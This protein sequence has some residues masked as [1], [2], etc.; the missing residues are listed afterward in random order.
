MS[1]SVIG[2]SFTVN[3]V[4]YENTAASTTQTESAYSGEMPGLFDAQLAEKM[5]EQSSDYAITSVEVTG[6][7]ANVTYHAATDCTVIV[8]IYEDDDTQGEHML[9]FG[10][11]ELSAENTEASVNIYNLPKYFYLKAYL[12][13]TATLRPLAKVY[14]SPNY[15]KSMGDFFDL[16]VEDFDPDRVWNFDDDSGNNFMVLSKD[17]KV[18]NTD[19]EIGSDDIIYASDTLTVNNADTDADLLSLKSGDPFMIFSDDRILHG[20]VSDISFTKDKKTAVIKYKSA[21]MS[22]I[23]EYVRIDTEPSA[24]E[25]GTDEESEVA[26]AYAEGNVESKLSSLYSKR[27]ADPES[28]FSID[29]GKSKYGLTFN[30]EIDKETKKPKFSVSDW[31]EIDFNKPPES[32]PIKGEVGASISTYVEVNIKLYYYIDKNKAEKAYTE[33]NATPALEITAEGEFT[34]TAGKDIPIIPEKPIPIAYAYGIEVV[35]LRVGLSFE[36]LTFEAAASGTF[37]VSSKIKVGYDYT[38]DKKTEI[39]D[40]PNVEASIEGSLTIKFPIQLKISLNIL[41]MKV[42]DD[43]GEVICLA[44]VSLAYTLTPSLT[45][46]EFKTGID[47][48]NGLNYQRKKHLCDKLTCFNGNTSLLMEIDAAV[49]IPILKTIGVNSSIE[50]HIFELEL[51]PEAMQS[52]NI[53]KANGWIPRFGECENYAYRTHIC[54]VDELTGDPIKGIFVNTGELSLQDKE[55]CEGNTN[56]DGEVTFYLKAEKDI[57][58]TASDLEE[59]KYSDAEQIINIKKPEEEDPDETFTISMTPGKT[60][61]SIT[62]LPEEKEDIPKFTVGEGLRYTKLSVVYG[63]FGTGEEETCFT[64]PFSPEFIKQYDPYT[65]GI[66]TLII[67]YGGYEWTKQVE[68]VD[69][70]RHI[71]SISI[72]TLPDKTRYQLNESLDITGLTINAVFTDGTVNSTPIQVTDDMVSGFDSTA[73]GEK[74]LTVTYTDKY[75]DTAETTFAV[76]VADGRIDRIE[77]ETLPEITEYMIGDED[78]FVKGATIKVIYNDGT[79]PEIVT[80]TPSMV[81]GFGATCPGEKAITVTYSDENGKEYTTEFTVTIIDKDVLRIEIL[82]LLD[83]NK[84]CELNG[85]LN[86]E[87]ALIKVYYT[88]GEEKA[89]QITEDMTGKFDSS[90]LGIFP[91]TVTYGDCTANYLVEVVEN[92][93]KVCRIEFDVTVESYIYYADDYADKPYG[94]DYQIILHYLDGTSSH[95]SIYGSWKK[96]ERDENNNILYFDGS[97]GI[98]KISAFNRTE[99]GIHEITA[100]YCHMDGSIDTSVKGC[101]TWKSVKPGRGGFHLS[102]DAQPGD[103]T[104]FTLGNRTGGNSRY[105]CFIGDQY[106]N[107]PYYFYYHEWGYDSDEGKYGW[108]SPHYSYTD[109]NGKLKDPVTGYKYIKPEFLLSSAH[110]LGGFD[111]SYPT[112]HLEH[113]HA[114]YELDGYVFIQNYE[115]EEY[116]ITDTETETASY[117]SYSDSA[118]QYALSVEALTAMTDSNENG[119]FGIDPATGRRTAIYS[120]LLTNE[121]YNY[122]VVRDEDAAD[123]FGSNNLLFIGQGTTDSRGELSFEYETTTGEDGSIVLR[124]MSDGSH[125]HTHNYSTIW[126]ADSTSH[127]HECECGEKAEIAAHISDNGVV[128]LKPT[129]TVT[130]VKTY[131]CTVCGYILRTDTIPALDPEHTHSYGTEWKSDSTS[132][133]HEC[134]CGDKTAVAQHTSDSGIVTVQPTSTSTGVRTYSCRVCGYVI[135]RESI[136]ETAV[137][138][139]PSYSIFPMDATYAVTPSVSRAKLTVNALVSGSTVTLKWNG[140]KNADK[141]TVYQYRNGKYVKVKSTADTSVTFKKLKNGETY[142]FLVRYTINGR[143]SPKAYSGNAA[144]KV[145]YKPLTKATATQNSIKL[146]WEAVP[147]AKKYAVYRSADGKVVKLTETKKCSVKI[148]KLSPDTEYSYIVRAYVDGKWTTM[149]KSDIVTVKTKAE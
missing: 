102:E 34:V 138:G 59:H 16:T 52:F 147:E 73:T 63:G 133:W 68:V 8:G 12:V 49:N 32:K 89:V 64:I 75:G 86:Y 42:E 107:W 4:D 17:A 71:E 14:D 99:L 94:Q 15:T 38:S 128:T 72:N 132:H 127:W 92:L 96:Q 129:E 149:L 103:K 91:V 76:T 45:L 124:P 130:G 54:I 108:L 143:L 23:F 100:E 104:D 88:D 101:S 114:Y 7:R 29:L 113:R 39:F 22:D 60:P 3:A 33:V 98:V 90:S 62:P 131:S 27:S 9:T 126:K 77:M 110:Y 2:S 65:V 80:V 51:L 105:T 117:S 43:D 122:Y 137:N 106:E 19:H 136:P 47:T 55:Y 123:F 79:E 18:I 6:N 13:D 84:Y 1:F 69:E 139:S 74:T 121:I 56:E 97:G 53:S 58:I 5:A 145:Y 20:V 125:S 24:K 78:F 87:D 40:T 111:S 116:S 70:E 36:G 35:T 148:N 115:V 119:I 81:S 134:S 135:R 95:R 67:E 85:E 41:D 10:T 30:I 57:K 26:S 109:E 48:E 28:N 66:Q 25:Y 50:W 61:S 11:T 21:V 112:G 46:A 31:D 118:E 82:Q 44:G 83:K 142:K 37:S 120:N 140:I 141:Y 93:K 144:V 146:T